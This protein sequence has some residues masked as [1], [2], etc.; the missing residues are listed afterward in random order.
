MVKLAIKEALQAGHLLV[1]IPQ[2]LALGQF[3]STSD[4]ITYLI[5]LEPQLYLLKNLK[6]FYIQR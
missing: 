2:E 5:T 1:L 4:K 6:A 3:L